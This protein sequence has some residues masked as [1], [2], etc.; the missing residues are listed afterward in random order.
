MI[1][2][3]TGLLVALIVAVVVLKGILGWG[4]EIS[5]AQRVGLCMIG[6]GAVWAAPTRYL[7]LPPGLGDLLLFL[8]IT[9]LVL[10]VFGRSLLTAATDDQP[11]WPFTTS[12]EP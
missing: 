7:G 9:T 12:K 8:G 6:A 5:R 2:L 3:A 1:T 10:S 11:D 4:G